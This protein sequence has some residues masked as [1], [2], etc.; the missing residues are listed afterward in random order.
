MLRVSRFAAVAPGHENDTD[1]P[2]K[3]N[4]I[5]AQTPLVSANSATQTSQRGRPSDHRRPRP[6]PDPLLGRNSST[7]VG[8][9]VHGRGWRGNGKKLVKGQNDICKIRVK[10]S[11]VPTPGVSPRPRPHPGTYPP[12]TRLHS[13]LPRGQ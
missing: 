5:D 10:G 7:L 4:G 3:F 13:P 11:R 12:H 2:I 9:R 1:P 8:G 6:T